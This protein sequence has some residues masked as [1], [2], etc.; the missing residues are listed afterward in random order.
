MF[1]LQ[2]NHHPAEVLA[3]EVFEQVMDGVAFL[4]AMLLKE[5]V[6]QI[7]AGFECELLGKA[8]SVVAV[9]EDVFDLLVC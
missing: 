1:L 4:D 7:A 8:K 9:E 6:C 3:D 5:L 2:P